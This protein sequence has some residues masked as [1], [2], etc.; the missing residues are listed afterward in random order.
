VKVIL[1]QD[2]KGQGK[3]GEAAEVSEGYARNFLL[4]HKLAMPA[5]AS[6]LNELKQKEAAKASQAARDKEKAKETAKRLED[7]VVNIT[8]KA[9]SG[10]RLFGSITSQEIADALAAQHSINVD[11]RDIAIADPIKALGT[12][13]LKCRLGVEVSGIL[14]VVVSD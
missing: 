8:A 4:P 11:K 5:T 7:L 10:G 13:E 12:Y 2:V 9:G 3:K 6:N 1:L 14:K